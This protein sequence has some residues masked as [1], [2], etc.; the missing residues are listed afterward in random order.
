M[1]LIIQVIIAIFGI[2]AWAQSYQYVQTEEYPVMAIYEIGQKL[3]AQGFYEVDLKRKGHIFQTPMDQLYLPIGSTKSQAV[4]ILDL[5]F[6]SHEK[7]LK[8]SENE[9]VC[10]AETRRGRPFSLYMK[11][12][13]SREFY[14]I[15]NS[16][17]KQSFAGN[18]KIK[19]FFGLM[20]QAAYA[21]DPGCKVQTSS[22][23]NL[24]Q[25]NSVLDESAVIQGLGTCLSEVVRSSANA[26][27][28]FKDSLVQMFANPQDL[29][30]EISAQANALK[31]FLVHIKDEV[32]QL[33]SAL[34]GL[35]SDLILHLGCQL[36]GEVLT[37]VA[38]GV[39]TGAG[40]VKLSAVLAKAV[41][42]LNEVPLLLSKLNF[43]NKSGNGP[44]AREVLSCVASH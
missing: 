26:F 7:Y 4:L 27:S 25:L 43:L 16:F 30:K 41:M 37:S 31:N 1:S 38:L 36:G 6:S 23:Q 8:L 15:C 42:K 32:V 44:L 39:L 35:D 29:W 11:V 21:A 17:A 22:R 40:F 20:S 18:S 12:E 5:K 9:F 19:L 24:N 13:S 3:A 28:G 34:K 14:K 33:K 10:H 2:S